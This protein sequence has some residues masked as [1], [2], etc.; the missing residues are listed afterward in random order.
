MNCCGVKPANNG[1]GR[2]AGGRAK[3]RKVLAP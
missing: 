1:N 2:S 3:V